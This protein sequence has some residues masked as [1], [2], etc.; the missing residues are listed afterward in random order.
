MDTTSPHAFFTNAVGMVE[1]E[2]D[3]LELLHLLLHIEVEHGRQRV[4]HHSRN[5]ETTGY[6]DRSLDLDLLS[7]GGTI[8]HELELH[9]PHPRMSGRLFVLVPLS[10][11]APTFRDP[12]TGLTSTEMRQQLLERIDQGD[13]LPQTITTITTIK[14]K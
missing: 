4:N 2:L 12:V 13:E 9:L 3:P 10:E 11:I 1:T 7:F 6:H 14:G 8:S 5:G